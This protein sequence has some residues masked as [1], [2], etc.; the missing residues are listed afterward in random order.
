MRGNLYQLAEMIMKDGGLI[1]DDEDSE[2]GGQTS[3]INYD[4][5]EY[6]E[7]GLG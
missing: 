4:D 7:E 6:D 3:G 2:D 5:Q 1:E